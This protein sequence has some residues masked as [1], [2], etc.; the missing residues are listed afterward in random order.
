ML[1][2]CFI[3]CLFLSAP[4]GGVAPAQGIVNFFVYS[5]AKKKC[6]KIPFLT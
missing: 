4:L 1:H 3:F 6:L 2:F 5:L